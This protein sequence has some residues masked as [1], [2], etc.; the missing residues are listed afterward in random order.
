MFLKVPQSV[1]LFTG[2]ALQ[3]PSYMV[4]AELDAFVNNTTLRAAFEAQR[5][6]GAPWAMAVEPGVPHFSLSL[7]QRQLTVDWMRA[8]LPLGNAGP[9]RQNSPQV[10]FFGDPATGQIAPAST[11]AGDLGTASWFPKRPLATQWAA[12]IG[13]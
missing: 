1:E 5:A 2:E 6:A 10:G 8:I 11:F 13:L 4:L 7:A 3:I 9:F 12:F